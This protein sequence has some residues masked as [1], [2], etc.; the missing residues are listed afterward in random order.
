[1][2]SLQSGMSPLKTRM[3]RDKLVPPIE[4]WRG[5][6]PPC[7]LLAL[8]R[9]VQRALE[10]EP[11]DLVGQGWAFTGSIIRWFCSRSKKRSCSINFE[12]SGALRNAT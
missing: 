10:I 9:M 5:L 2:T 3:G 11:A 4:R 6:A 8:Q 7:D 1:M 12:I